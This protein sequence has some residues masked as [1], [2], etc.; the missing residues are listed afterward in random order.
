MNN[1]LNPEDFGYSNEQVS[2]SYMQELKNKAIYWEQKV[3]EDPDLVKRIYD[4]DTKIIQFKA[5]KDFT[6][7]YGEFKKGEIVFQYITG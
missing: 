3:V 5:K 7:K 4:S 6:D 1:G 2:E